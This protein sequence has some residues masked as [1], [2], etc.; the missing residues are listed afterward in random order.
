MVIGQGVDN[1]VYKNVSYSAS[2][3]KTEELRS[4]LICMF[5]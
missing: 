2:H 4:F 5:V 1:P 3:Q